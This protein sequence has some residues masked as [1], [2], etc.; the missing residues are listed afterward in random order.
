MLAS[1]A[2]RDPAGQGRPS[3]KPRKPQA[4][5]V[6][7]LLT[8]CQAAWSQQQLLYPAKGSPGR[9]LADP[10]SLPPAPC[11]PCVP[12][13]RQPAGP[14]LSGSSSHHLGLFQTPSICCTFCSSQGQAVLAGDS[15]TTSLPET[16]L[17]GRALSIGSGLISCRAPWGYSAALPCVDTFQTKHISYLGV[18]GDQR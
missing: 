11:M 14:G 15:R 3:Q 18:L 10:V 4:L 6:T 17:R 8:G 2:T 13:E 5:M 12:G 7:P 9:G 1:W 16:E